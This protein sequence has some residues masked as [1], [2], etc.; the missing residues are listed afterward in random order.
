MNNKLTELLA[1]IFEKKISAIKI[2]LT[3][4]DIDGWDSLTQMDLVTSIEKEFDVE[5]EMLEIVEMTSIKKIIEILKSKGV[6]I[7][8]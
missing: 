5:L 1:E 3:K 7:G 6:D 4:D 8:A 2:D